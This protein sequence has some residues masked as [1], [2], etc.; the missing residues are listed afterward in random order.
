MSRPETYRH[1]PITSLHHFFLHRPSSALSPLC[2]LHV[3]TFFLP[4]MA[5]DVAHSFIY[6]FNTLVLNIP[7]MPV[8]MEGGQS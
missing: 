4:K 8:N 2:R 6:S 3:D 5:L 7:W 1:R